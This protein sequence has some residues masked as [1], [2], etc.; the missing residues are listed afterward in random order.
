M[1][2]PQ[3]LIKSVSNTL[4]TESLVYAPQDPF[5]FAP[6]QCLWSSPV[7]VPEKAILHPFY[8][9]ELERFF[10]DR[11]KISPA[12]L[13]TLVEGVRSLAQGTPS[14]IAIKGMIDAINTMNPKKEALS[15]L[16]D[17]NFLP[18]RRTGSSREGVR[19]QNCRSNFSIID[20]TKLAEI[21]RPHTGFLDFSLEEVQNL[22]PFLRALDLSHKYLSRLCTE[23][24]ACSDSGLL[25]SVLTEQFRNR[26]HYLLR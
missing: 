6:S 14:V 24:T 4:E 26:A 15:S 11:L 20:R 17:V 23:E 12:S 2:K 13:D 25:D 7:P 8:P 5:W 22:A 10:Q 1:T 16:V 3:I 18:I 21:F 19:L 9:E